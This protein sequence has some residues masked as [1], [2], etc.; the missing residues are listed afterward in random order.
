MCG[1]AGSFNGPFLDSKRLEHLKKCLN[2]R[3]PDG[4]G[5]YFS[6]A[7]CQLVHSR[8]AI[9][10]LDDRAKQPFV[11]GN[12]VISF[13]GEIY[14]Y[15]ELR[16]RLIGEGFT[17]RTDSDTEVLAASWSRWG[18]GCLNLF[19]G[20]WAIAVY[21]TKTQ[22]L[23]L[24]TDAFNEKPLYYCK[25]SNEGL[26]F[27]SRID[28]LKIVGNLRLEPDFTQ[29]SNYL[30]NGYKS[31]FKSDRCFISGVSRLEAGHML[32]V[33][34]GH[35]SK[36]SYWEPD[37][38][39]NKYT[40][41]NEAIESTRDELIRSVKLRLRSDVPLAFCLSGGIDSNAL[42]GAAV[43]ECGVKATAF[44]ISN[45]DGRY[46]EED[47][48]KVTRDY[49]GI[50]SVMVR[51]QNQSFLT[52]LKAMVKDRMAPIATI[53]YYTQNFLYKEMS[54][55]GF[56]VGISGTGAD[57]LFSGYY[58]HHLLFLAENFDSSVS[59]A[60]ALDNWNRFISP[61]V[62]NPLLQEPSLYKNNPNFR[63]HIYYRSKFYGA[64]LKN[65]LQEN[66]VERKFGASLL[67]S[68]MMNEL[69]HEAVPVILAEDDSNA[70]YHSIENRSPYLSRPLLASALRL[71]ENKLIRDG[72]AKYYLRQAAKSFVHP[73][74]LWNRR[75]IGFNSSLFDFVS[76]KDPDFIDFLMENSPVFDIVNRSKFEKYVA[77]D[78]SLNSDSKF[79]FNFINTK[80]Y[81]QEF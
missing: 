47:L 2:R 43:N 41:D 61:I 55:A 75:K 46:D 69:F 22:E 28:A 74:I 77:N 4:F 38:T 64:V 53:S 34:A 58:D 18:K 51:P 57:E 50:D 19:D 72:R 3:G 30:V 8:L 70:M 71:S 68:R 49:L 9:I 26:C 62:R 5:H 15:V 35:V 66:F 16:A 25:T 63:E 78:L 56:K 10:D 29:I 14:N 17:F 11:Y 48:V 37:L 7:G 33:R 52:S 36:K 13:N 80:L 1:I 59:E 39:A 6:E 45:S 42:I 24:A 81:L 65:N 23:V 76:L 54:D 20:M 40:S 12:Y 67:R 32:V 60:E 44:T 31:L 79:L 21:D 73:D 27:A